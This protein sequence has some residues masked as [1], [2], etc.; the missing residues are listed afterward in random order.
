MRAFATVIQLDLQV[1]AVTADVLAGRPVVYTT[2]LAYDEVA[3]HSGLERPDTLAVLRR[4]DRA[5]DRIT[6]AV[7]HAPRPYRIVV[8]S[9]HGQSQGATFLQRYGER[10][11]DVVERHA[12]GEVQRRG[13]P[14]RRGP[15]LAAGRRH[16]VRLARHRDRRTWSAPPRASTSTSRSR[17]PAFPRCR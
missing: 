13:R 9:D 4:V 3:H 1:A 2:F 8:L 7:P 10:L 11:E 17:S 14:Q 6:S 5:I 12:G 16:R 15:V